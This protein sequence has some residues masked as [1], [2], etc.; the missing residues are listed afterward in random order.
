M[1]L[2]ILVQMLH[3]LGK[4]HFWRCRYIRPLKVVTT[5]PS[6]TWLLRPPSQS[7]LQRSHNSFL[8]SLLLSLLLSLEPSPSWALLSPFLSF[9]LS[10]LVIFSRSTRLPLL[11]LLSE[12]KTDIHSMGLSPKF[13]FLKLIHACKPQWDLRSIILTITHNNVGT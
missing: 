7:P 13:S 4:S 1:Y 10:T 12:P 11:G 2:W 9:L 6:R 5:S 8:H 3:L